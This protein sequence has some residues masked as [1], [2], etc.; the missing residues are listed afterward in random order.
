MQNP[1]SRRYPPHLA[2]FVGEKADALLF[3]SPEGHPLRRTKFRP[4]WAEA[5]RKAGVTGL[6]FHDLRGT[7]A[8]RA[9]EEG[10]SLAE[11]M[12]L[13]R[14]KTPDA[15]MRYQHAT[16]ERRRMIADRMGDLMDAA[17]EPVADV[18]EIGPR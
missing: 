15:A 16:A 18:V 5:C 9:G 11:I 17:P 7:A 14:H 1:L 3:T 8:T 10:A 2:E 4:R 6:H 13:L 12:S